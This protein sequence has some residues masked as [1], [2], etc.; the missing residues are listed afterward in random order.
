MG[1]WPT[2]D[3][4]QW[5]ETC[6]TLHAHTQVLGKLAV[7]LAPAEPQLQH[8]ALRLTARGWETAPLPAPDGSGAFVVALDLRR[9]EAVVESGRGDDR[10]VALTPNRAV[11]DIASELLDTIGELVGTVTI[12]PTPQEVP[13]SVPLDEDR[14]H[15]HYEPAQVT[16]YFA[17]ATQAA[18]VLAAFRAPFRGRST[19]V[20]AWWGSFDLAVNLFSGS[21]AVP[22]SDDFIMRNAMDAQE[23]AIGWWPGDAR[24]EKAAFY[25]YAHPAP[26]GLA[27]VSLAPAAGRWDAELGEF[28]L[29]WEDARSSEDPKATALDFA[30]AVYRKA[31]VLCDWDEA[32]AA[33][34]E[35]KP[36]AVS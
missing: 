9:H 4:A 21:P 32:L 3:Y 24:Y 30:R 2:V 15:A 13:W 28:V 26:D 29:D 19:P 25:A 5:R 20:N 36:P 1:A 12:D 27:G 33:T 7:A 18:L 35:G 17:A 6:D 16:S 23:I 22:P 8:A 10:R 34:A 31:C 14:E 11:G